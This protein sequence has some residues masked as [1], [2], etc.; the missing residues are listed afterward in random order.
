MTVHSLIKPTNELKKKQKTQTNSLRR[1]WQYM[2]CIYQH[3]ALMFLWR[4]VEY[5]IS[6]NLLETYFTFIHVC[7]SF[8][9]AAFTSTWLT[10]H[11]VAQTQF[12]GCSLLHI[13]TS[14]ETS[15]RCL[16]INM[17]SLLKSFCRYYYASGIM[18]KVN[19]QRLSYRF[20]HLTPEM[21]STVIQ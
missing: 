11:G 3:A 13:E 6:W 20:L 19:G 18:T 15:L 7:V 10:V 9:S 12:I 14:V 4:A 1:Y 5:C 17:L 8:F 16:S 2:C 21:L